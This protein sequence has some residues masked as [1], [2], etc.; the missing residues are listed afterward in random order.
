MPRQ[1]PPSQS[2]FEPQE[3]EVHVPTDAVLAA[4]RPSWT[5]P[6]PALAESEARRTH[7]SLSQS[8]HHSRIYDD[9]STPGLSI[10]WVGA[11]GS[12]PKMRRPSFGPSTPEAS[13]RAR[14]SRLEAEQ[15]DVVPP[16]ILDSPEEGKGFRS[17]WEINVKK[18]VGDAV[19]NVNLTCHVK[20]T[21]NSIITIS[22]DEYKP[23]FARHCSCS[24]CWH[25]CGS[26][27][28]CSAI[29]NIMIGEEDFSLLTSSHDSAFLAFSLKV[30][31]GM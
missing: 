3:T 25:F 21:G 31:L 4:R 26:Y 20:R 30:V 15:S 11:L 17:S 1:S 2:T 18:L 23:C 24:V 10:D 19:G 28:L 5:P 7:N 27:P 12:L 14:K 8:K 29:A 6:I 22:L 9:T 16:N 13:Q